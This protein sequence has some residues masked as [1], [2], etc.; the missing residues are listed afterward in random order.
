MSASRA[1]VAGWSPGPGPCCWWRWSAGAALTPR[2]RRRS[3][4]GHKPRAVHD[5]S[6]ILLDVAVAVALGGDCLSDVGMLRS[7]PDVFGT[8]AS[9]PTVSRLIATLARSGP[10]V[11]AAI[12]S[13]RTEV[14][15]RVW[16]LVGTR[17]PAADGQATVDI[18]GVLVIAHSQK[19]DAAPTWKKS[20]GRPSAAGVRRPR[21]AGVRGASGRVAAGGQRRF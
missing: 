20:F 18:D 13:A 9:D 10:K 8:V 2:Y 7:E 21:P 16:Q 11:L 15:E 5:P 4:R 17:S 3:R 6:K 12:R 19:Q 14:R 1:A